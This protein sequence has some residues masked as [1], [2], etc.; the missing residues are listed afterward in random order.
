M[1]ELNVMDHATSSR[2]GCFFCFAP[3][4]E[5]AF[6]ARLTPA[7]GAETQTTKQIQRA[8]LCKRN[9]VLNGF[10]PYDAEYCG[11]DCGYKEVSK[12]NGF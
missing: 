12:V 4:I 9:R 1:C 2:L 6:N 5:E 3:K 10:M 8:G 7:L 11:H